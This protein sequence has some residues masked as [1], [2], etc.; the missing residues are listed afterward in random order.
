MFEYIKSPQFRY[1]DRNNPQI[2]GGTNPNQIILDIGCGFKPEV[3]QSSIKNAVGIDINFHHGAIMVENPI[4]ADAQHIPIRTHTIH[5][6]NCQALLE[7]IPEPQKC[8]SDM[9]RIMR[10]NGSGF[11]LIPVDSRQ[12]YQTMKRFIKEFPFSIFQTL[13]TLRKASTFWKLPGMLHIRQISLQNIAKHFKIT[14]VGLKR[15]EHLWYAYGPF[16]ILRKL[17]LVHR[18]MVD[19]YSE[20]YVWVKR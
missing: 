18:V 19:E 11:I 9:K 1:K 16:R 13:K 2:I 20:Y 15:H 12:I 8:L 5:F 7:H 14:N 10:E 6:C 17:G 3:G 4:M